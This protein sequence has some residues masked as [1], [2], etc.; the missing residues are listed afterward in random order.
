MQS[1]LLRSVAASAMLAV[2]VG[3]CSSVTPGPVAQVLY[4]PSG[5]DL[6]YDYM[7]HRRSF[8]PPPA[9]YE[10]VATRQETTSQENG[11][12]SWKRDLAA[13]GAGAALGV[14][15]TELVKRGVSSEVGA[16]TGE[17]GAARAAASV[18]ETT[19]AVEAAEVTGAVV[20]G[21]EVGTIIEE[22]WWFFL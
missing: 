20:E 21:A 4:C 3:G 16:A 6:G 14:A 7:C 18:A 17:A 15:G 5:Y 11:G 9:S 13:A 2:T 10:Q 1:K 12:R 22:I 8:A 19:G